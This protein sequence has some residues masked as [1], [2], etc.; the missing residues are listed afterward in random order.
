MSRGSYVVN[1]NVQTQRPVSVVIQNG[2]W[3]VLNGVGMFFQSF[4]DP[5]IAVRMRAGNAS[6]NER[7]P[8]A[9]RFGAPNPRPMG[10]M[11]LVYD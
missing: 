5:S 3:G 4:I 2:F 8:P 9:A 10:I 7:Q 6:Q 11:K 1:G